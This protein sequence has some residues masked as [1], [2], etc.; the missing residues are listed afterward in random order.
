MPNRKILLEADSE[1]NGTISFNEFTTLIRKREKLVSELFAN[2]DRDHNGILDMKEVQEGLKLSMNIQ[3]SD[4]EVQNLFSKINRIKP[5]TSATTFSVNDFKRSLVLFPAHTKQ[6]LVNLWCQT[7]ALSY[8]GYV[9]QPSQPSAA[10]TLAA[11]LVAGGVS[12]YLLM[13]NFFC[14]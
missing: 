10:I 13:F 14:H 2:L 7:S 12:R 5:S 4:A 1:K 9:D 8:M 6:E 3:L 11:G